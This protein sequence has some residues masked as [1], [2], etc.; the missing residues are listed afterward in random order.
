M[1]ESGRQTIPGVAP[2]EG[3]RSH[4]AARKNHT[5]CPNLSRRT[6]KRQEPLLPADFLH[7]KL[8]A[9]LPS[10]LHNAAKQAFQHRRGLQTIGIKPAL[11]KLTAEQTVFPPEL[12]QLFRGKPLQNTGG[13]RHV[14]MIALRGNPAIAEIAASVARGKQ[15]SARLFPGF[16]HNG[17]ASLHGL[18][19][20]REAGRTRAHNRKFKAAFPHAVLSSPLY[21]TLSAALEPDFAHSPAKA[22]SRHFALLPSKT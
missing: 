12:L 5:P 1:T 7:R 2:T 21:S 10:P 18:P 4:T 13:S 6:G 19:R 14:A 3:W 8:T 22:S 9:Q 20:R 15:L 11:V 17:A 16:Q